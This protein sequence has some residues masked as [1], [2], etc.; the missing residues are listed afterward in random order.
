MSGGQEYTV[1]LVHLE[2]VTARI[3]ALQGFVEDSLTGVDQRVA[4]VHREWTGAAATAHATAHQ[5]WQAGAQDVRDGIAAMRAA[6][7]TAHT[8][9][10]AGIAANLRMFGEQA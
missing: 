9:Y 5:H 8:A 10:S 6:A 3:A 7:V 4:A 2:T 1:D